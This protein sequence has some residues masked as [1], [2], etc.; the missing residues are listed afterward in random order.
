[1]NQRTMKKRWNAGLGLGALALILGLMVLSGCSDDEDDE[2]EIDARETHLRCGEERPEGVAPAP[3]LRA[4]SGGE[5][6]SIEPGF[7]T[8]ES[9]GEERE[10]LLIAPEDW[11]GDTP[12]PTIVMWH[13]LQGTAQSFADQGEL[14]KA[15]NQVGFMAIIPESKDGAAFQWP[16]TTGSGDTPERIQEEVTF[17]DDMLACSS[18]AYEID[19]E[20]ISSAGISAG[21]LWT[22]QLIQHRSDTLANFV[23]LSGGVGPGE[24][25]DVDDD[26][27]EAIQP[28]EGAERKIP[29]VVLWGGPEDICFINFEDTSRL[30]QFGLED[31]GHFFLECIHNCAHTEPPTHP[32]EGEAP[33]AAFW[34]F[35]LDHPRWVSEGTSPYE[36]EGIRSDLPDWCGI[37]IDGADIRTID[38]C[39]DPDC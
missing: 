7:N 5:C 8:I 16:F 1:M 4:Y 14:Q 31:D 20:C 29:G 11:D 32:A 26:F 3:E 38:D 15:A 35:T 36:H 30:L 9:S 28:W 25:D 23:A 34:E 18:Q 17:F 12:L 22:S 21:A 37:G 33:M 19:R 27:T 24:D 13:W 10:F 39:G 2:A 6:P